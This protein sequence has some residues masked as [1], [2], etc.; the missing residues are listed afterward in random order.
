ME[1]QQRREQTRRAMEEQRARMQEQQRQ[2]QEELRL[3]REAEM[4]ARQEQLQKQR[5]AEEKRKQE[6]KSLLSIRRVIQK[7]RMATIETFE[8]A[9]KELE[10]ILATELVNCGTQQQTI[11]EE[12][13]R[14]V[15]QAKTRVDALL[16]VKRKEQEKKEAEE[17]KR[18]EQE[19]KAQAFIKEL[20]GLVETAEADSKK[21]EEEAAPFEL[22][23]KEAERSKL[24][25][26]KVK[27][28]ASAI[29][30]SGT[31]AKAA[32]NACTQY[33]LDKGPDMKDSMAITPVG[34]GAVASTVQAEVKKSLAELLQR[35]NVCGKKADSLLREAKDKKEQAAL[36][37]VAKKKNEEIEALFKKY[38]K[39]KDEALSQAEAQA[40][41]KSELKF[42][43]DKAT[44]EKIWKC[45]VEPGS[46]G[47][48]KDNIHLLHTSVGIA[49]ELQRDKKRKA[50]REAKE[51]FISG[52]QDKLSEKVA[53]VAKSVTGLE[54]KIADVEKAV[55]PLLSKV[56]ATPVPEMVKE[57]DACDKLIK[58]V[59][60]QV[61]Q[62]NQKVIAIPQGFDKKYEDDL[63]EAIKDKTK[64]LE[65]R[66]KRSDMRLTRATNLST[67]YREK[68]AR[69]TAD[70]TQEVR[71]FALKL[72]RQHAKLNSLTIEELF[73]KINSKSDGKLDKTQFQAF[74][75]SIDHEIKEETEKVTEKP[76][77]TAE[78]TKKSEEKPAEASEAAETTET[79]EAA[80]GEADAPASAEPEKKEPEKKEPE[81]KEPEKKVPKVD[82]TSEALSS[83][84]SSL[85]EK[86][87][88]TLSQDV[89]RRFMK[90]Y[91]KVVQDTLLT[92]EIELTGSEPVRQIKVNEILEPLGEPQEETTAKVMRV[93]VK[94]MSDGAEGW[95]TLTSNQKKPMLEEVGPFFKTLVSASLTDSFE[96]A[97]PKEGAPKLKEGSVLEVLEWPKKHEESELTR[98]Q[99]KVR[100]TG[101]VGWLT[102]KTKEG[103]ILADVL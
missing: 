81:K 51:K 87:S 52:L 96:D 50:A 7:V 12:C 20:T 41:A 80:K 93:K 55:A 42:P 2:Q 23:K 49:K 36:F 47:I 65:L 14:I 19:E 25:A 76:A 3:K 58:S 60:G 10:E 5:E 73:S 98:M 97:T 94:A 40:Y 37:A 103:E 59:A 79:T 34:A 57:A 11:K 4:K 18:K 28:V 78:A 85:L 67:C 68:A 88:K 27:E 6:Q 17:K 26:D 75:D 38:D 91:F 56:K 72:A 32:A 70:S 46:K 84:F 90:V 45:A 71:D 86:N 30:V 64:S 74:F 39:D 77:E 102:Q 43:V 54:Q 8:P 22:D 35:I 13:D 24:E 1:E 62:V 33:I 48:S 82:L 100:V 99:V 9:Q 16:E 61:S 31:A 44:V 66:M 83:L 101:A 15:E 89:F 21:L 63:R 95:A 92:K 69:K 29:E 53:G